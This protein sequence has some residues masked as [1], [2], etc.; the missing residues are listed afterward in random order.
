MLAQ[1][2]IAGLG[3]LVV[4][5]GPRSWVSTSTVA[6]LAGIDTGMDGNAALDVAIHA[7]APMLVFL[8]VAV[9]AAALAVRAGASSWAAGR[10]AERAAGSGRA[11][12]VYVCW[13]TAV[14]TALVSLDGAVVLMAPVVLELARRYGAPLRPL[15]L[16]VVAVANSSS[17]AL[18][19]GNPTN[20]VVI[21]RLGLPLEGVASK[22]I[23]PALAATVLCAAAVA[24]RQR[25][26]LAER[27]REG[28]DAQAGSFPVSTGLAGSASRSSRCSS[29]CC[30]WLGTG[31]SSE[32]DSRHW[33]QFAPAF[34]CWPPSPTTCRRARSWRPGWGLGPP[35][36]Q[37]SSA[38]RSGR[39]PCRKAPLRH[40]S[41]G[42]SPGRRR[43]HAYCSRRR[44]RPRSP[45]SSS[46][47]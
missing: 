37:H 12:F 17:L 30:R 47:G 31:D 5:V 26:A 46:S 38:C 8:V 14:L 11:L 4:S 40:S 10:L 20:L 25:G 28:L 36:T 27:F 29:S 33:L 15:L 42:T 2:I 32:A 22:T 43:T 23:V 13:L 7:V 24:W 6:V 9:G 3:V 1:W 34:P 21:E 19:E 35:P 16:G 39:S 41:P 18:P 44:S 45:R